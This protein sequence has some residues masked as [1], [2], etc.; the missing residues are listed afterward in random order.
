MSET[1][2]MKI[3]A[4]WTFK[5]AEVAYHFDQ[6]VKEQLPWYELITK[7]IVV[8]ARHYIEHGG[9]VYDIG[10]STGNIT[11]AIHAEVEARSP[12]FIGI[13]DSP[14]MEAFYPKA[15]GDYVL[16]DACEFDYSPFDLAVC[17]LF[18]QFVPLAKRRPLLA[19]LIK[20]VKKS[21]AIVIVDK[22]VVSSEYCY[23]KDIFRRITLSGKREN[24][25]P[26]EEILQKELS[27][28]GV[29]R[30]VNPGIITEISPLAFEFFRFGE[31]AGWI[32][33]GSNE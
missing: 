2:R 4:D 5:S 19:E 6:H 14:E 22:V 13:D 32:I 3:P 30:P 27:I 29:Q 9:L 33:P 28:C 12:K 25:A 17:Y 8:I 11:R 20:K 15:I 1:S 21:G 10:C 24:G 23:S 18:L 26:A 31:F 7:V 16:A